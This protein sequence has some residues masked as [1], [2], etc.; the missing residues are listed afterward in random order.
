MSN[1][2]LLTWLADTSI[3]ILGID[4]LRMRIWRALL[5]RSPLIVEFN[6]KSRMDYAAPNLTIG[7]V[8]LRICGQKN[9]Q[10]Q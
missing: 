6:E 5:N 8:R 7:G 4:A 1:A 3:K 9:G 10:S 2:I